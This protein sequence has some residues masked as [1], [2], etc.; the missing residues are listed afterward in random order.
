MISFE[1]KND[2][3][4]VIKL[5]EEKGINYIH[6]KKHEMKEKKKDEPVMEEKKI[7]KEKK[8]LS[9]EQQKVVNERMKKLRELKNE[10]KSK[11]D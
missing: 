3:E 6:H 11:K 8:V 9:P 4:K 2:Q 1:N 5:L 10:R 7:K